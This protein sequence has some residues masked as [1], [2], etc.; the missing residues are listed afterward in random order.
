MILLSKSTRSY[1][2]RCQ[3]VVILWFGSFGNSDSKSIIKIIKISN[4]KLEAKNNVRPKEKI[5]WK[6]SSRHIKVHFHGRQY[7]TFYLVCPSSFANQFPVR[8]NHNYFRL[9]KE[10][11]VFSLSQLKPFSIVYVELV[12]DIVGKPER[13]TKKREAS[14]KENFFK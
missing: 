10:N 6:K 4:E 7:L 11:T 2:W 3:K 5:W 9:K 8:Y 13:D 1:I 12:Q 14:W